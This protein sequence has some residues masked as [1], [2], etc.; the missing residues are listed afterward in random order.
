M[1]PRKIFDKTNLWLILSLVS[2]ALSIASIFVCSWLYTKG[3]LHPYSFV[4]DCN[5]FLA[6]TNG[7]TTF[8]LFKNI[9]MKQSKFINTVAATM[10]GVLCIHANSDTMRRFLWGDLFNNAGAYTSNYLPLHAILTVLIVFVA[11]IL[12]DLFRIYAIEKPFFKLY[13]KL[14]G[15]IANKYTKLE[16]NLCDKYKIK[17]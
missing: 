17:R 11:C 12:I 2:I 15:K 10:F 5:T 1:Y 14:D 6:L 7:I 3:Y 4:V 9:K 8:L 13:D 16:N